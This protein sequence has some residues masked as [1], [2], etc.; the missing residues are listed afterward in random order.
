MLKTFNHEY[1]AHNCKNTTDFLASAEDL[2]DPEAC[3]FLIQ[4]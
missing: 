2:K 1:A 3:M 4:I